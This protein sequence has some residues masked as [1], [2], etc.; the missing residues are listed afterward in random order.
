[1]FYHVNV[2][3]YQVALVG[4]GSAEVARAV[5]LTRGGIA[6]NPRGGCGQPGGGARSTRGSGGQPGAARSRALTRSAGAS[7]EEGGHGLKQGAC[8]AIPK[9]H[10]GCR[11]DAG[12]E[13]RSFRVGDLGTGRGCDCRE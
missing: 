11:T 7:R 2:A 9:P 3:F 13:N 4:Q 8:R 10:L 6:V 5:K 1:M 12:R